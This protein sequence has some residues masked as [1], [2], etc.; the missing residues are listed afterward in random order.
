MIV[1]YLFFEHE[2]VLL[3]NTTKGGG[4][5][6]NH[7]RRK[8]VEDNQFLYCSKFYAL[9]E[10]ASHGVGEKSKAY[11]VRGRPYSRNICDESKV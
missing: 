4:S 2:L 7:R 10:S 5:L 9:V 11:F 1:F 6:R 3:R 8:R